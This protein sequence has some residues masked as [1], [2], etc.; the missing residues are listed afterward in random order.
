MQASATHA[1]KITLAQTVS[2]ICQLF[3]RFAQ[4]AG[5]GFLQICAVVLVDIF[6]NVVFMPGVDKAEDVWLTAA[7]QETWQEDA[8]QT[9]QEDGSPFRCLYIQ[10]I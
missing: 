1:L 3:N 9:W 2:V 8:A 10:R 4:S 6:V 5:P 7:P